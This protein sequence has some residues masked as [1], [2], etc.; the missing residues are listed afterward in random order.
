M[1]L[2]VASR[3]N[4]EYEAAPLRHGRASRHYWL[5]TARL[6]A[7]GWAALLGLCLAAAAVGVATA[8]AI[9][10]PSWCGASLGVLPLGAV[11]LLDRRRWA[12]METSFGWGGSEADVAHIA[13]ELANQGVT[14]QVHTEPPMQVWPE[15][16]YGWDGPEESPAD[17][18]ALQAAS[19]SYRNR[20]AKTVEATLRA[21]GIS[22]PESPSGFG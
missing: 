2:M 1:L 8:R 19:L 5:R 12:A 20:D 15:P 11:V 4:G 22:F 17:G 3:G 6:N 7:V 13:S 14:A 10:V 18:P 16:A 9:A 21:H